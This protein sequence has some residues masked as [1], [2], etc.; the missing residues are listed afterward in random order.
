MICEQEGDWG[1]ETSSE[2]S[3]GQ[4]LREK[5]KGELDKYVLG[6]QGDFASM[7]AENLCLV[8]WI[9]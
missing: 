2:M 7:C 5:I 8:Y 4:R 6:K 3:E 1:T 9:E